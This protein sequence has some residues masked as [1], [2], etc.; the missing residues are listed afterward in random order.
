[1]AKI[2]L[3]E[4]KKRE[5]ELEQSGKVLD[6]LKGDLTKWEKELEARDQK[7]E[8]RSQELERELGEANVKIEELTA[9]LM[10]REPG[11]GSVIDTNEQE[12]KDKL[13]DAD[14]KLIE[15]GCKAFGIG[16][17]YLENARIDRETGEAV[18]LTAGGSRV[19]YAKDDE[20]E[21]LEPIKVDGK[22]RKGKK[23]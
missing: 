10:A 3:N 21:P 19:R 8:V 4:L 6:D 1:M 20:V 18:L 14:L 5:K 9:A 17:E 22:I 2:D 15:Q 11:T 13:T 7:S 16:M 23:D 12:E